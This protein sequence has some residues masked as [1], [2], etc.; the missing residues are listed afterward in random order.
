[1]TDDMHMFNRQTLGYWVDEN[2]LTQICYHRVI[3]IFSQ[4][5]YFIEDKQE[6][7][8]MNTSTNKSINNFVLTNYIIE[9]NYFQKHLQVQKKAS[10][11]LILTQI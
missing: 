4:G 10:N 7:F 3:Y 11:H 2:S 9:Y 6:V 1:M 5:G 8:V